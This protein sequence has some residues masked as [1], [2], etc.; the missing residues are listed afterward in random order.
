MHIY[1]YIYI[2]ISAHKPFRQFVI[3]LALK[4]I[5]ESVGVKLSKEVV[6]YIH[7]K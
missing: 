3:N 6:N 4:R 1:I 2:Y 5:E 7:M